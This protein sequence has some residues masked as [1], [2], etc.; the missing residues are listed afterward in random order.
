MILGKPLLQPLLVFAALALPHPA[1]ASL[2][3]NVDTITTDQSRMMVR[4][5]AMAST[6]SGA[7]H[8][9]SLANGGELREYTN[10]SGIV[11]AVRWTGPGKPD[12]VS[13][14]G[15]SFAV[16]QADNPV[17]ARHGLR[18]A[19]MVD[20]ADL[21]IVTGGRAGAFWGYAWLPQ[22]A[23]AGFDPASM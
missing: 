9:L 21:K 11:F 7:L 8:T 4:F 10:A 2:G 17:A 23:P 15:P 16:L 19:P 18:R 13:L 22:S 3:G 6:G 20:R 12:L 5:R 1:W 14:L